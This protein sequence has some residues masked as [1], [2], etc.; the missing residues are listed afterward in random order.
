V[1]SSR[2][3]RKKAKVHA[4]TAERKEK[5]ENAKMKMVIINNSLRPLRNSLRTLRETLRPLREN[6]EQ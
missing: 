2:G 4:E 1:K 6:K 3:E 5:A